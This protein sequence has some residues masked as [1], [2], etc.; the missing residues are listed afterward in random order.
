M[1]VQ[2]QGPLQQPGSAL[3]LPFRRVQLGPGTQELGAA[4]MLL[5]GL[6]EHR[7]GFRCL[8][9]PCQTLAAQRLDQGNVVRQRVE[10]P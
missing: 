6:V 10:I 8:A 3:G 7:P 9:Q 5:Q 2:V 4:G 1:P